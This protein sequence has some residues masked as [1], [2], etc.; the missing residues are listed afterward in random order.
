MAQHHV[1]HHLLCSLEYGS[2]APHVDA[3]VQEGISLPALL[4]QLAS[5]TRFYQY[6]NTQ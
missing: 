1:T 5:D 3:V 2:P 4:I 6:I